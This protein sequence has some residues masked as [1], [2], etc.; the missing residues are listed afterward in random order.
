MGP[1]DTVGLSD[2]AV[3]LGCRP[4][5]PFVVGGPSYRALVVQPNIWCP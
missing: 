4:R 2:A 5:D 3:A 1:G